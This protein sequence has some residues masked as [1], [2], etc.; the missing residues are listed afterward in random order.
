M[1]TFMILGKVVGTVVAE[2]TCES[3]EDISIIDED[4]EVKEVSSVETTEHID[5]I[6]T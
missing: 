4:Y 3:I 2:I 5:I 6:S 1:K